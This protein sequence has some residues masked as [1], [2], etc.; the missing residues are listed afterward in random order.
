[1]LFRFGS[2]YVTQTNT[3]PSTILRFGT[4]ERLKGKIPIGLD[5]DVEQFNEIGKTGGE[6]EHT[7]TVLEM[8]THSHTY[9]VGTNMTTENTFTHAMSSFP[10]RKSKRA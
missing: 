7:L 2:T 1:M 4:W 6:I 9:A 8:P 5:E 3:N 10:R